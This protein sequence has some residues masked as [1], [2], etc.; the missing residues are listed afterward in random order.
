MHAV[1]LPGLIGWW[2]LDETSGTTAFDSSELGN[3][4]QFG[5][6]GDPQ[7]VLGYFGGA[8]ELDGNDD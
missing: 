1:E 3:D 2:K 8:G 7:W 6:E 4:G 5:P